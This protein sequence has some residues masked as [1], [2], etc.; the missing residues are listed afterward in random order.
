MKIFITGAAGFLGSWLVETFIKEGHRVVGVDNMV[1][2][3]P[4]NVI[5]HENYEFRVADITD[6]EAMTDAAQG[7][8]VIYHCGAYAYEGLSVFSPLLITNNIVS[9]TVSVATAG[10]RNGVKRF[11]NTSS[12]ARY[13]SIGAP[14]TE[15]MA[16]H[17]EDPY[18]IAK[19]AAEL[20]LDLLGRIHKFDVI[21]AVPHN[22]VGP[23]QKSDDPFR[24]V[25]SIMINLMLQGRQPIVYG[26]GNQK[27]CFSFI[28]D[29]ISILKRFLD[30]DIREH[31]ERF[32]VGPDEDFITINELAHRLAKIMDFDLN[33]E[34]HDPRPCEVQ[35]AYCSADKIRERFNYRTTVSLDDGLRTIVDFLRKKGPKKFLYHLP[36]EIQTTNLPKTWRDRLF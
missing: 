26:D 10:I 6:L 12:M 19:Y 13:G 20:Q 24:N 7:C 15:D 31:G 34:Y 32:N 9:G 29:D 4:A 16:C 11:I 27:R 28:E 30:C 2:G 17:P 22:I 23:R 8:D 33:I 35:L 14:F 3:D 21:H 1:G 5:E 25:V 18:G 36:I